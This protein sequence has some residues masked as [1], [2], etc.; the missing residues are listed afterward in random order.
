MTKKPSTNHLFA[1]RELILGVQLISI[2]G[3]MQ[4]CAQTLG[5]VS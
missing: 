3:V 5:T 4:V 2:P 1:T